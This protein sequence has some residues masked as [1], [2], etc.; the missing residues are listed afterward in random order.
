[1]RMDLVDMPMNLVGMPIDLVG[2]VVV[3]VV[4]VGNPDSV[5]GVD[6]MVVLELQYILEHFAEEA[7]ALM[8]GAETQRK[9]GSVWPSRV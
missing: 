3:V 2:V 4:D 1:M 6:Q 7:D 5:I 9:G 8:H